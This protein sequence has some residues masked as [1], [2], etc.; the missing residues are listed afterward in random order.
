M[1]TALLDRG[2]VIERIR[3]ANPDLAGAVDHP[4]AEMTR[5]PESFLPAGW[6][7][8]RITRF[9]PTR[10]LI[11]HVLVGPGGA[12]GLVTGDPGAFNRIV[13]TAG[14]KVA[15]EVMALEIARTFIEATKVQSRRYQ[16]IQV[17]G[18]LPWRPGLDDEETG[19]M[20]AVLQRVRACLT[21]RVDAGTDGGY[22]VHLAVVSDMDLVQADLSVASGGTVS[23]THRTLEEDLPF[24]YVV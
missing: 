10:S 6:A 12:G 17:P 2:Q 9:F 8:A 14:V 22:V 21:P 1:N 23:V 7:L 5:V 4:E 13:A 24:T 19:R 15:D 20:E 18:E 16:C 3:A 11:L